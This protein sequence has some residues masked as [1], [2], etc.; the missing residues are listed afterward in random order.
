MYAAESSSRCVRLLLRAGADP[1]HKNSENYNVLH[2]AALRQNDR[3][4]IKCFVSAGADIHMR[5]V[6]GGMPLSSIVFRN[7]SI[8]AEILL[9]YGADV[10]GLDN[11]GDSALTEAIRYYSNDLIQVLLNRGAAYT[12][13][14]SGGNSILHLAALSG[15]LGTIRILEA[16]C[17]RNIDPKAQNRKRKTALQLVWERQDKPEN[18]VERFH[19]LLDGV[20]ARNAERV[21]RGTDGYISGT[22]STADGMDD[23]EI[24]TNLFVD[25]LEQQ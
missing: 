7:N 3:E 10:D 18:F 17:L 12:L 6:Y 5:N 20:R 25:A 19:T 13:S 2:Y 23:P 8:S 14:N 21:D 24:S 22:S 11:D 4:I 16:A 1:T 15:D 9:D